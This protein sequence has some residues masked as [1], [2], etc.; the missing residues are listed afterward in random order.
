MKKARAGRACCCLMVAE[1]SR[2][3][4]APHPCP[5]PRERGEGETSGPARSI[6][7]LDQLARSARSIS[8]LDQLA[9]SACSISLLD[10]LARSACLIGLSIPVCLVGLLRRLARTRRLA[11]GIEDG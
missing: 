7:S 9:R 1:H 2:F 4:L 10:Q 5:S 3:A 8:S 6:S 11:V